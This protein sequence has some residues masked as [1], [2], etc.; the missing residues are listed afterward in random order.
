MA[1]IERRADSGGLDVS[2]SKRMQLA[3]EEL[4]VNSIHHGYGGECDSGI[5]LALDI[6]AERATLTF[7]DHAPPFN[8]NDAAPLS[9]STERIGGVGLNLV[10]AMTTAIRYRRET[11]SNVTM[12]DFPPPRNLDSSR[13]SD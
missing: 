10:R 6:D 13:L 2:Q 11:H 4:F 8:L 5:E 12:L 3:A 1:W 7:I 9:A